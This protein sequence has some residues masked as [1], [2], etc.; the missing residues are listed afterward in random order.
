MD[1]LIEAITN[2]LNGSTRSC[3][4]SVLSVLFDFSQALVNLQSCLYSY[5]HTFCLYLM[6]I[7]MTEV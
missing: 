7:A 5:C 3:T 1:R 4:F 2:E 6:V